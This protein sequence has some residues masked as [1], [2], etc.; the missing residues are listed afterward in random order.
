MDKT[1]DFQWPT[2]T[3]RKS[4]QLFWNKFISF[5]LVERMHQ[6]PFGAIC[7]ASRDLV[8]VDLKRDLSIMDK[9]AFGRCKMHILFAHHFTICEH[10]NTSHYYTIS[11]SFDISPERLDEWFQHRAN[12]KDL[13]RFIRCKHLY[14]FD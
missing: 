5:H 4:G 10:I 6:K 3:T 11:I 12:R 1:R 9:F 2:A 13:F 7:L 8:P 14:P